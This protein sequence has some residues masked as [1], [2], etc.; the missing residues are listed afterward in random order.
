MS[1]LFTYIRDKF[2]PK[3]QDAILLKACRDGN[4]HAAEVALKNGA[5]PNTLTHLGEYSYSPW[6]YETQFTGTVHVTPIVLAATSAFDKDEDG[7][8]QVIQL[9][10][11]HSKTDLARVVAGHKKE[12]RSEQHHRDGFP[13]EFE[14]DYSLS[15]QQVIGYANLTR[16]KQTGQPSDLYPISQRMSSFLSD[17]LIDKEE[18]DRDFTQ[19]IICVAEGLAA[20]DK[21]KE[22]RLLKQAQDQKVASL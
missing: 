4:P 15:L 7:Y 8:Y 22:Q 19:A 12:W 10:A 17:I 5:N 9:L 11:D 6:D 1:N 18:K 14:E 20:H 13:P 21:Y 16:S 3:S 2:A